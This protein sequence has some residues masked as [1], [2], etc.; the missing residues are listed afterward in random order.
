MKLWLP[1]CSSLGN[2]RNIHLLYEVCVLCFSPGETFREWYGKHQELGR[3][4]DVGL[5]ILAGR[6]DSGPA[7]RAAAGLLGLDFLPLPVI[8]PVKVVLLF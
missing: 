1:G 7:I 6:E 3:H 5:E 2:I 8:Q 4:V